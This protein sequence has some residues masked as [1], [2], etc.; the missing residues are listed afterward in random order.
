MSAALTPTV[1]LNGLIWSSAT[2]LSTSVDMVDHERFDYISAC[3]LGPKR[4]EVA[5]LE[6]GRV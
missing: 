4:L 2:G 6:M 3:P 5:V 1:A